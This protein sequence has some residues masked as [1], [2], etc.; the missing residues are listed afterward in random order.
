M[1]RLTASPARTRLAGAGRGWLRRLGLA[2][3]LA[4]LLGQP[5]EALAQTASRGGG[6][7]IIRDAEIE[8]LLRDYINPIFSA[9]GIRQ[10]T[11][12]I[13][14]IGD[15]SFN[16]FVADG[17]RLFVNVGALM[18][19]R[20]P[21]E[22]IGVLAHESGHIKG[23]HLQ[24]LRQQLAN[25]QI[26]AIAGML[27]GAG[28]IAGGAVANNRS[29]RPDGGPVGGLGTGA[30]GIMTGSQELVRRSLLAYQRSEEQAADRMAID[31]LNATKQS[32]KGL[33]DTFQRFHQD[34]MF[35]TASMDPYLISHPLP[36]ER[37]ASLEELAHRSPYWDQKDSPALQARHDLMRAK[38][39]GFISSAEEVGRR[40]PVSDNSMAAR[41]ARAI[42]NYRYKRLN[43]ALTQIDGLIREQPGNPYFW[44]LK[45]QA[46]LEFGRAREA[47]APLRKAV[48]MAPSAQPVRVLLGR[49]LV[50]SDDPKVLDEA[51]RELANAMQRDPE[52]AEGWQ[53]LSQAYGRKGDIGQA[54]LAAARSYFVA[55]DYSNAATQASRA[56]TKLPE[57][58]PGW[59]KA[60][61]ILNYRPTR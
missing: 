47:I 48:S 45:G 6:P 22:V 41:Y 61:D 40:Y 34:S 42:T 4:G 60:E 28:A 14:L 27:L 37:I 17:R 19:A 58:S 44:E 59:L 1:T 32:P 7:T 51:I 53:F 12:Q 52:D 35:K 24:R 54:E 25:A 3:A 56:Q 11:V 16:A 10:G 49:A 31:Y 38:L 8:Q 9:A 30:M 18:D 20:T 36:Q 46:L 33:L 23:G 15:R 26:L 2:G 5:F 21:N 29:T 57:N 13:V 50:A 39:F 55:G 43:E